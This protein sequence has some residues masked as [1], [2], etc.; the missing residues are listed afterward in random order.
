M[1]HD[2]PPRAIHEAA[3]AMA[4]GPELWKQMGPEIQG[5]YI[6]WAERAA[7]A[8]MGGGAVPWSELAIPV[9]LA[10]SDCRG[11]LTQKKAEGAAL[12][13][14]TNK[15]LERLERCGYTVFAGRPA[16]APK[17]HSPKL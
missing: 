15:V 8:L 12:D 10:L 17:T 6:G 16:E 4:G 1:S 7:P 11:S 13:I 3:I 14:I 2:Y 9:R 5:Q